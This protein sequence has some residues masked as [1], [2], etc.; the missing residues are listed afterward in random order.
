MVN[1]LQE[2]NKRLA[3]AVQENKA[4]GEESGKQSTINFLIRC[5][6]Y[7]VVEAVFLRTYY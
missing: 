4:E 7:L 2:E 3:A 1:R 5:F 6:F